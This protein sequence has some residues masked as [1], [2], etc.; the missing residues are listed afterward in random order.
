MRMKRGTDHNWCVEAYTDTPALSAAC[1]CGFR[2]WVSEFDPR[3]M[4]AYLVSEYLY[5]FCP[6]CG[7]KKLRYNP[8]P[9]VKGRY[10]NVD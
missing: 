3:T 4:Q 2:Y 1:K 8:K 7:A 6:Q 5:H 9:I 10:L